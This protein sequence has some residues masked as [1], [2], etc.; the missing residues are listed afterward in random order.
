MRL[1]E[2]DHVICFNRSHGLFGTRLRYVEAPYCTGS[3]QNN[4][5]LTSKTSSVND[6]TKPLVQCTRSFDQSLTEEVFVVLITRSLPGRKCIECVNNQDE[7][8]KHLWNFNSF[9]DM[10]IWLCVQW[11]FRLFYSNGTFLWLKSLDFSG[12]FGGVIVL[13]LW[14][15]WWN[16]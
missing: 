6:W 4:I 16:I 14:N 12:N 9:Y 7:V 13:S 1:V 11:N 3:T 8:M 5:I 15:L 10:T 2:T